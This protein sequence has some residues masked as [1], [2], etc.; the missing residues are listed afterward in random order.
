[1]VALKLLFIRQNCELLRHRKQFQLV[2]HGVELP[3]AAQVDAL[4]DGRVSAAAAVSE[5]RGRRQRAEADR[6]S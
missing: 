1:M 2:T 6:Q 3:I 4:L 5:L